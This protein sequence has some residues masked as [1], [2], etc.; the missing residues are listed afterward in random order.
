MDEKRKKEVARELAEENTRPLIESEQNPKDTLLPVEK[1]GER[2]AQSIRNVQSGKKKLGILAVIVVVLAALAVGFGIYNKPENRL[3]R[4]LDLGERYLEEQNYA[5][6]VLAFEKAIQIDERCMAAYV[7]GIEAYQ[8]LDEPENLLAFYGKA[9]GIARSL[10]GESLAVNLDA[11]VSIYLAAEDVFT[12]REALIVI[13]EEGYEKSG[14]DRRVRN[15]LVSVYLTRAEERAFGD[16]YEESLQDYDRMLELDGHNETVLE[17]LSGSLKSYLTVL[18]QEDNVERIMELKEKYAS[19]LPDFD[20]EI[21]LSDLVLTSINWYDADGTRA[22]FIFDTELINKHGGSDIN[23]KV[24][25]NWDFDAWSSM[26][27]SWGPFSCQRNGEIY[28][29]ELIAYDSEGERESWGSGTIGCDE[30]GRALYF[31]TDDGYYA[32]SPKTNVYDENG[33]LIATSDGYSYIYDDDN[34]LMQWHNSSSLSLYSDY[35]GEYTYDDMDNLLSYIEYIIYKNNTSWTSRQSMGYDSNGYISHRIYTD[36]QGYD[37]SERYENEYDDMGI[38]RKR[39]VYFEFEDG[40]D[41]YVGEYEFT[42]LNTAF[43]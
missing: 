23:R 11:V 38:L 6:A 37:C 5:E 18:M 40:S 3:T 16:A 2:T 22:E 13:W 12:D 7:N 33:N 30:N 20:F 4:Q 36:E 39:K 32:I 31:W 8:H 15:G 17:S 24:I 10:E 28:L 35:W 25:N 21:Y 43:E 19:V 29:K 41:M 26:C 1:S 42:Y 27:R 14:Q 34:N 9:L